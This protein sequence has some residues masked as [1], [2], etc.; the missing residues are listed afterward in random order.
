[1]TEH[2][3]IIFYD[4]ECGLCHGFVRFVLRRDQS[5]R[6]RFAPLQGET[7]LA[8][9]SNAE[10]AKL[11]DSVIIRSRRGRLLT[12]SSAVIYVL[13]GLGGIWKS[14][15]LLLRL[16]PRPARDLAYRGIA[17]ARKLIFRP[18]ANLCPIVPPRWR[19]KFLP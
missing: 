19:A 17:R 2:R 4:G 3:D 15:G 18:P 6:F 16:V 11:P 8:Q 10:R 5:G 14:L 13:V 9:T 7:F 1:M 12:R